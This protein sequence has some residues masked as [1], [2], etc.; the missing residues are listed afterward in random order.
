MR[1]TSHRRTR[2]LPPQNLVEVQSDAIYGAF[3]PAPE[4]SAWVHEHIL[5]E[6]GAL[7]NADHGHLIEADL[8]FLWTNIQYVKQ[9]NR[10]A[11]TAEMP[12]FRCGPWQKARQEQ[13]LREWFGGTPDFL[14][15]LDA[16]YA[17]QVS[18][19]V[20]AALVE[21]EL[22]HCAQALDDFG[23]PKFSRD[24]APK[25]CIRGHD[26]EEFVGIVR[27]YGAGNSAGATAKLV[28][29]AQKVPEVAQADIAKSCGTCLQLVA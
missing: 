23:A 17:S 18:D 29:A 20:W 22:Y 16:V 4:V 28:Q 11:G 21:H 9:M 25:F 5:T 26:V 6:G 14:I 10:V 2:P 12:M 19:T 24:G 1:K 7:Y 27:R 8:A 15:T 13:Q 3:I